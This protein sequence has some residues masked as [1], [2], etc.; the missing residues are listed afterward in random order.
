VVVRAAGVAGVAA[1]LLACGGGGGGPAESPFYLWSIRP[2]MP[3]LV[4]AGDLIER[5]G[6][7]P[8][9]SVW[10]NGCANLDGGARRCEHR[11]T[12]PLGRL[13]VVVASDNRVLYVAFAPETRD[14]AFDDSLT[15]MERGWMRVPGTKMDAHGVSEDHPRG[16]AE[17]RNGRWRA[18]MT[19]DGKVC[20]R[21]ALPCPALIQLVDWSEGRKYVEMKVPK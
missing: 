20:E 7:A 4:V 18:F 9:A 3:L 14:P 5:E 15:L 10:G 1:V 16:V 11:T 6:L 19:F 13:V 17:M 8:D 12:A 2:G 21:T